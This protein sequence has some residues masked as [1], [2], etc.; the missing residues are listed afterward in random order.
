M[1]SISEQDYLLA[2]YRLRGAESPVSTGSLSVQLGV[3]PASVTGMLTKLHRAGL[4]E[5]TPYRGVV[6]TQ[7][8]TREAVRLLRRHRLWEVFLTRFLGLPWDQVHEEAHRLEHATSDRVADHL[9]RFLSEPAA[10][11]HG[12]AIP[13]RNGILPHRPCRSLI[14]VEPGRTVRIQEVPDADPALLRRLDAIGIYP[15]TEV[16]VAAHPLPDGTLPVRVGQDE[17]HLDGATAGRIYASD[18]PP[19]GP[20]GSETLER[21]K[22]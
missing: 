13:D 8:G 2:I 21:N 19:A 10:D 6:L 14:D 5:H 17:H 7:A 15:G 11:P 3:A 1:T 22:P 16:T 18:H 20:S 4:V 9:A 12:Q